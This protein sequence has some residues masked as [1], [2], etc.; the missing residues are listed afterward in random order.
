VLSILFKAAN[1]RNVSVLVKCRVRYSGDIIDP[2]MVGSERAPGSE[3]D[4]LTFVTQIYLAARYEAIGQHR[5]VG[6]IAI[7]SQG[8]QQKAMARILRCNAV[9]TR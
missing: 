1:V 8:G 5:A 3:M 9:R 7:G 4:K 6:L 2:P